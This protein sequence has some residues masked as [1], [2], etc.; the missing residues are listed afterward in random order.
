ME[1]PEGLCQKEISMTPS[2]IKPTTF[3]LVAQYLNQLRHRVQSSINDL[4][5]PKFDTLDRK[6]QRIFYGAIKIEPGE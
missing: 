4:N 1:R 5:L 6:R 2:E 3:R